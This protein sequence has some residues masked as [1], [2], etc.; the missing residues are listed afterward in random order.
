MYV[1]SFAGELLS[2]PQT[3][4]AAKPPVSIST[5]PS[6]ASGTGGGSSGGALHLTT[7]T[8]VREIQLPL[9]GT[10]VFQL[11]NG[12]QADVGVDLQNILT[13]IVASSSAFSPAD[14]SSSSP[15]NSHIE[16]RSDVTTFQ[17]DAD[18]LGITIGFSPSGSTSAITSAKGSANVT[19]GLI[20]MDFSLWQ[21]NGGNC[22]SIAAATS[23]QAAFTGSLSF[24]L[25]LA[26]LTTSTSLTSNPVLGAVLRSIII[27]GL[28]KLSASPRLD[29]LA[30][31]ASVKAY[32]SVTG[33][34]VLS[35]GGQSRLLPN[36]AFEIYA[37]TD[38]TTLGVCDV[39]QT[40]A[41]VHTSEVNT[42]SSQAVVDK[43]LDPR[44]ILVGDVVMVRNLAT[45]TKAPPLPGLQAGVGSAGLPPGGPPGWPPGW[46]GKKVIALAP[47]QNISILMPDQSIHNFGEDFQASLITQLVGSNKYTVVDDPSTDITLERQRV[48]SN[49]T[50]GSLLPPDYS[51]SGSVM[52]SVSIKV[53]VVALSFQTGSRG[54]Q[55]FYGFDE[56]MTTPF[57]DG[58]SDPKNEFPLK[59]NA[60]NP[61]CSESQ[62]E[63]I[64]VEGDG[65]FLDFVGG[66]ENYSAGIT[67]ARKDAMQQAV[68]AAI[69]SSYSAIDRALAKAPWLAQVD[70]LLPADSV[71]TNYHEELIL[72]GTGEMS[73]ILPGT[74]YQSI[75]DPNLRVVVLES[76]AS[77]SVGK[78]LSGDASKLSVGM[79]LREI[80][81]VPLSAQSL[82]LSATDLSANDQSAASPRSAQMTETP[83]LQVPAL[84]DST[85][86]PSLILAPPNLSGVATV[87]TRLE[88]L[89][90]EV[91]QIVFL[92]YRLW[93]Y[94]SYDQSYHAQ[95]DGVGP[96]QVP[97]LAQLT[98]STAPWRRQIGL[99]AMGSMAQNQIPIVA[100]I[101]SGVD[102]NHA[103]LHNALWLNPAPVVD[104]NGRKDRYGWD[105]ISNDSKPYDDGYHGTQLASLVVAVAPNVKIMPLKIFN[106]WGI[107]SSAAISAAFKYAVDHGAQVILVGWNTMTESQ[108]I[109]EGVA[110]AR[111]KGVLIV[112]SVG[113]QGLSLSG[114]PMYP[115]V[116]SRTSGNVLSVTS[117]DGEDALLGSTPQISQSSQSQRPHRS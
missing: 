69:A 70:A 108:A 2:E 113:D 60:S 40:V 33:T 58:L 94:F 34:L 110:Y 21:C 37:P 20:S 47:I 101:D 52:P 117:V 48:Q 10:K 115:A 97:R 7:P 29:E 32:D 102:Y 103:V 92:P 41:Y 99:D 75:E 66:Y 24:Q 11:P 18:E 100:V 68:K 6:G 31:T 71:N 17:L 3:W 109:E 86:L 51:W 30:W 57:N 112:C 80:D 78:L 1:G 72:L 49:S 36:Q 61:N 23:T 54:D 28:Q 116:L 79:V 38:A 8:P 26:T 91:A 81:A 14:P 104:E 55:M 16:L 42:V 65:F 106:P 93:R 19:V 111:E 90:V 88:A 89:A 25:D 44:G 43:I 64:T 9:V 4:A 76:N 96:L 15:C 27:D 84:V 35:A 46:I 63:L 77:G 73:G 56:R 85:H 105:F 53:S 5:P 12:T 98:A 87:M 13:G 114:F 82:L 62:Y 74:R 95:P 107:T 45:T 22:Y 83:A 39:F 50:T 67:V 59:T